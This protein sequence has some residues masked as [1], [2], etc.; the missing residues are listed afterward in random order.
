[1]GNYHELLADT[2]NEMNRTRMTNPYANFLPIIQSSGTGKSRTVHELARLLFTIPFNLR[3]ENESSGMS[4]PLLTWCK[5]VYARQGYAYPPQD[6]Y[7]QRYLTSPVAYSEGIRQA[8]YVD[9]KIR[10]LVFFT[11]LFR[12][13]RAV[14][15][16]DFE[17]QTTTE[18][19]ATA[20]RN[21]LE[22]GAPNRLSLY[23]DVA[24]VCS[25]PHLLGFLMLIISR[26]R[27]HIDVLTN[28]A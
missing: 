18:N 13:I 1:M 11:Q 6:P 20:W 25:S 12:A 10:Y 2:I 22:Q 4:S 5:F 24:E 14:L 7:V 16:K 3:G 8:K 23:N 27:N 19:L 9:I 15:E 17:P 21:Y 28:P 26:C